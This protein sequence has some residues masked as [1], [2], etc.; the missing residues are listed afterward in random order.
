[1]RKDAKKLHLD[2]DTLRRLDAVLTPADL[3]DARG[4]IVSS[5][6]QLC[7]YSRLCQEPGTNL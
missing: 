3:R 4:G 7:T 6:N 2:R 1:M 5:D